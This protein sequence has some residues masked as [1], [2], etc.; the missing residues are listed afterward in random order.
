MHTSN[1]IVNS[2]QEATT[3]GEISLI[4]REIVQGEQN[5][6]MGGKRVN[7][8]VPS[9]DAVELEPGVEVTLTLTL[10]VQS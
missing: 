8:V 2:K 7:I 1:W 3:A 5:M 4:L 10:A 9:E 6:M